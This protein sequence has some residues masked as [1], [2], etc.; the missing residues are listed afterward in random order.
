MYDVGREVESVVDGE[1][2][3]VQPGS[4]KHIFFLC[5]LAAGQGKKVQ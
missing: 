2:S 3:L 4:G 1:R 5:T